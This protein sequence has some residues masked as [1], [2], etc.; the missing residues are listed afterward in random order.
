MKVNDLKMAMQES[1]KTDVE[2]WARCYTSDDLEDLIAW[3]LLARAAMKKW[4]AR[5]KDKAPKK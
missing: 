5:R 4:E 1:G 2:V 3:L